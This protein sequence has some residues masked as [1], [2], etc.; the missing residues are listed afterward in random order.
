MPLNDFYSYT[1]VEKTDQSIQVNITINE[2]HRVFDGHFPEKPV[3]P[4]VIM[5]DM[6]R[7]VLSEQLG[8]KLLMNEAKE[9]K[10]MAPILPEGDQSFMLEIGYEHT[11]NGYKT[12]CRIYND[13]K[14]FTKLKA[15]F[16]AR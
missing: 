8:E 9:I 4:G 12:Q 2:N 7:Y 6:I 16:R 1:I 14:I 10:F 5:L 13:Q 11:E 15:T 3:T